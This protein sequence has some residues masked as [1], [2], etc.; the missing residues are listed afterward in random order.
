MQSPPGFEQQDARARIL[1]QPVRQHTSR[2]ARTDDHVIRPHAYAPF[3]PIIFTRQ[4]AE[5]TE[6]HGPSVPPFARY[7]IVVVRPVVAGIGEMDV[8]YA[9]NQM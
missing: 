9:V 2:R 7:K 8:G 1:A 5:N 3:I 4:T 6:N